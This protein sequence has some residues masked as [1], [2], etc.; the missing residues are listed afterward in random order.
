MNDVGAIGE[1]LRRF[2]RRGGLSQ[3]KLAE[4]AGLS[5]GVIKKIERGGTARLE[6]YH[7]LARALK[8]R[9]SALFDSA[10]PRQNPR[11]DDD[12]LDLLPLRQAISP[13]ITLSGRAGLDMPDE[14]PDLVRLRASAESAAIAYHRDKYPAMG[15]LLPALVRSTHTAVDHYTSGPERAEAL[16][17]RSEVLQ[18]AGRYLTQVRAYDLAHMALR[19]AVRDAAD[20]GD[21]LNAASGIIGQ[22][23]I[24]LRQGRLD[25]AEQL[26]SHT[27]DSME[28]R[29]SCA[30]RE[31]LAAWGWLLLRASAAAARNNRPDEATELARL[32]RTAGSAVGTGVTDHL[33]GWGT[34]GPLTVALKAIENEMVADRPD[35]VLTMSSRLPDGVGRATSDNWNRHRLDVARANATLHRGDEATRVLMALYSDAPEWLKHQRLAADTLADVLKTRK[36]TLTEEQRKL[37]A[38]LAVDG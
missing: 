27:A 5:P 7:A 28:P 20:A 13:P 14:E 22:A 17:V 38:H 35:R 6:T 16:A 4:L 23:W 19:D 15:E 1:R 24:L 32:A 36:R 21:R 30:P 3:E 18:M 31:E 25:E 12:K 9:T 2:R 8:V 29:I 26:A 10:G 37:A 33:R 11:A 34:F